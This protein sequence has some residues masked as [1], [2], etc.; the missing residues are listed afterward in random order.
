[1]G[2]QVIINVGVSGS[3]KS[4]WSTEY[5][6]NNIGNYRIN[7]DSIREQLVGTLDGYYQ[8]KDVTYLEKLVTNMEEIS[9]VNMLG[10]GASIIVDNT[11]LKPSYIQKWVDFVQAWNED[12]PDFRKVAVRFKL[13]PESNAELLKK[14]VNIRDAPLGWDKLN[15]IDKQV[16]SI[17]SAI[18]YVED[19]YKDQIL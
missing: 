8:R 19:N 10:K 11:N 16:S 7:R 1:M 2:Q 4:T 13:F 6:K 15:Y 18:A 9:F 5:I 3:G 17:R 14:R 12:L